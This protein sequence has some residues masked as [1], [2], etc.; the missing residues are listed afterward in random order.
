[1]QLGRE[2]NG[3]KHEKW[4]EKTKQ[5]KT[6]WALGMGS[7]TSFVQLRGGAEG[8]APPHI[9]MASEVTIAMLTGRLPEGWQRRGS[10]YRR[11]HLQ[12]RGIRLHL[13]E[14]M[15][16]KEVQ[17]R[18]KQTRRRSIQEGGGRCA[19]WG[20]EL[21]L[22]QSSTERHTRKVGCEGRR[23]NPHNGQGKPARG[24]QRLSWA[25]G[26][27]PPTSYMHR[28]LI[29]SPG[30]LPLLLL[31][32]MNQRSGLQSS[33]RGFARWHTTMQGNAEGRPG[34]VTSCLTGG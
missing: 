13:Q 4:R 8:Q 10:G 32:A 34:W 7:R 16:L 27:R 11:R 17:C 2:T 23:C 18:R 6:N 29:V 3:E 9:I 26:G 24:R 31:P 5:T 22:A 12:Q 14:W 33:V 1:M 19:K 20:E 28:R 30:G 25:V 21:G 15:Q